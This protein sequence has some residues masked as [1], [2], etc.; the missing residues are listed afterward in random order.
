MKSTSGSSVVTSDGIKET[1]FHH[2]RSLVRYVIE[3]PQDKAVIAFVRLYWHALFLYQSSRRACRVL[4]AGAGRRGTI[5]KKFAVASLD[6][7]SFRAW[8]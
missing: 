5:I 2:D 6:S 3:L 1:A 4:S 8:G 7:T